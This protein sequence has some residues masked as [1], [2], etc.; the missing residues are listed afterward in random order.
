MGGCLRDDL[1]SQS[2]DCMVGVSAGLVR[3]LVHIQ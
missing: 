3:L 1:K 2:K